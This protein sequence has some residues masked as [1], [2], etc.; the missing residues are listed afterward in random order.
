[1]G[2]DLVHEAKV[3]KFWRYVVGCV[4]VVVNASDWA[5]LAQIWEELLGLGGKQT[6]AMQ[7]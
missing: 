2:S 1:M 7:R 5:R 4:V 3:G 6:L